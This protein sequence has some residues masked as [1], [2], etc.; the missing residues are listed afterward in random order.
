MQSTEPTTDEKFQSV[1]EIVMLGT[2]TKTVK[3]AVAVL[4]SDDRPESWDDLM[5][6]V[7]DARIFRVKIKYARAPIE[8]YLRSVV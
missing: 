6:L 5:D 3:D 2:A 4:D 8:E 7:N 1:E